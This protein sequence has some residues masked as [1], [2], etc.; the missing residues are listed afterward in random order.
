MSRNIFLRQFFSPSY[1]AIV[2]AHYQEKWMSETVNQLIQQAVNALPKAYAPY[3]GFAVACCM[4]S[5]SKKLFTGVNVENIA[6]SQCICAEASALCQ[7]VSAGEQSIAQVVILSKQG[8]LCP[9]CGSCRQ[10][11]NEFAARDC[12]IH[13]CDHERPLKTLTI[14]E[15]LPL[16]F[17]FDK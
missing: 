16:A 11:I 2:S 9:P 7:M 12:L 10:R 6:Y 4:E 17:H 8:T 1:N 13:L 3:S 5:A 15:L 14:E